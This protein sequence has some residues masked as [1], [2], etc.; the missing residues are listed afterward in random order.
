MGKLKEYHFSKVE[1]QIKS[2]ELN[3]NFTPYLSSEDFDL[4]Y[5]DEYEQWYQQ[6]RQAQFEEYLQAIGD[7]LNQNYCNHG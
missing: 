3:Q 7:G 2:E 6:N 1:E 4:M 5:D